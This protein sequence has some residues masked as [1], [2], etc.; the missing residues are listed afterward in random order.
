M[1]DRSQELYRQDI[2]D[3]INRITRY[4]KGMSYEQFRSDEK[5]VDAVV[6]NIEIIGEA[7]R[8]IREETKRSYSHAP[9]QK[10]VSMRNRISHGYFGVSLQVVWETA[11]DDLSEYKRLIAE[12]KI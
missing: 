7:T 8:N 6:R 2:L 9:W 3:A 10:A 12:V 11:R 1:S 5:T 4:V